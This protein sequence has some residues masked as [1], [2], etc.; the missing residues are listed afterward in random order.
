MA[1]PI[2][3]LDWN[4]ADL[5]YTGRGKLGNQR[6]DDAHN[7]DVTENRRPLLVFEAA[8]SRRLLF[9]GQAVNVEERT[10]R[11]L[12]TKTSCA[13]SCCSVCDST[14]GPRPRPSPGHRTPSDRPNARERRAPLP[15]RTA[16]T[17]AS[18]PGESR[19]T[20]EVIAAKREQAGQDHHAM[21]HELNNFLYALGCD[22]ISEI[23]GA[24]DWWARRP[25]RS[26]RVI[27]E[28][29]TISSTTELSQTRSGFARLHEYR[30]EYETPDDD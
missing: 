26:R 28:G 17:A 10:D 29:K 18:A 21:L 13:T 30:M 19:P 15:R 27:F 6:R 2:G 16:R 20:R 5:I 24:I 14:L 22:D 11:R 23:R 9:R 8:G 4:G 1:E 25:D 12:T 3:T 7:F